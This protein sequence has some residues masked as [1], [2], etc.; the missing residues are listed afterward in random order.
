MRPQLN[1]RFIRLISLVFVIF[2]LGFLFKYLH[3]LEQK[4]ALLKE[5][6]AENHRLLLQKEREE[7]KERR[8]LLE[9]EREE[10]RQKK[11]ENNR[12]V[13]EPG[14]RINGTIHE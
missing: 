1:G 14:E 13:L 5:Q 12:A 7:E 3:N 6:E 9:I 8:R 10:K 11:I 2:C 4:N